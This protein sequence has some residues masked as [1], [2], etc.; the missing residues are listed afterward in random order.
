MENLWWLSINSVLVQSKRN[1]YHSVTIVINSVLNIWFFYRIIELIDINKKCC[2]FFKL[3]IS[4]RGKKGAYH[5]DIKKC[6]WLS[7]VPLE[8]REIVWTFQTKME[9][10]QVFLKN[11]SRWRREGRCYDTPHTI[12]SRKSTVPCTEPVETER[13]EVSY[14]GL[15]LII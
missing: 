9:T 14:I 10:L 5:I 4:P 13:S 2:C 1:I 6:L 7:F 15:Y 3:L 11:K 12:S 8:H